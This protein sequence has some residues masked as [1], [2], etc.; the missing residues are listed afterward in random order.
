MKTLS[1]NLRDY[2]TPGSKVFTSSTK[3]IEVRDSSKID[4]LEPSYYK[5]AI[6]VPKDIYSINPSFLEEFLKN[7]IVKLGEESFRNKFSFINK[8]PY[9]IETDLTEAIERIIRKQN[10]LN[11]KLNL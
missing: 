11:W 8:G 3:G 5:I 1:I 4:I 6:T 10:I 2:R 9:N 7:L